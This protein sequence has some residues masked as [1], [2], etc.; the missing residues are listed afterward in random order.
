MHKYAVWKIYGPTIQ[1]EGSHAG[2]VVKAI[3]FSNCNRWSGRPEDKPSS[4]CHFCDTDFHGG[5][6]LTAEE[7]VNALD[8]LGPVKTVVLT[9]GEPTLQ[10]DKE[11]LSA[12]QAAGYAM[13]LETNGSNA[14]GDLQAFF[15]H[16]TM[17]PKQARAETALEGCDDIKL[18][19]P[20]IAR[21]ITPEEFKGFHF[22]QGFLQPLWEANSRTNL[23][24]T[25]RKLVQLGEHWRL[26]LQMQ[27]LIGME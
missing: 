6:Q 17:S 4:I 13:H 9:G 1:G 19:W 26:S 10:V 24:A 16:I 11:L 21:G 20:P 25:L 23:D 14:L 8:N 18:L 15:E 3:R 2:L 12:I 27:K 7:I 5:E 22:R